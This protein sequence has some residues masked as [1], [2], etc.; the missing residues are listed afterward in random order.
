MRRRDF[1]QLPLATTAAGL[2]GVT[3]AGAVGR[4]DAT[5]AKPDPE[6][7]NWR[8]R[9]GIR[10]P[11]IVVVVLDDIGFADLG[12][13]GSELA[14]R[15]IDGLA[16]NGVRFSNF[17]VTA[18]CA[19]TRACLLTG[20]NAH[21][22]GVGNI[23]EWGRDHPGYRGWIRK[24]AAT[25]AEMLRPLGYTTLA[26]GKWHLSSLDD[27]NGSGPYD[28]WPVGR[29]F[30]RWYGFHGNAMDH[31]HPE[32]FENTVAA[33]PDKSGD[34]HLSADLVERS[35]DYI[36]DHLGATPHKP[37]LH[38]LAFGA[39]HFPLHAPA[40]DIRRH[41]GRYDDGWDAV[42][43]RRFA[44]QKE[45]RIIPADTALAPRNPKISAWNA[46]SRE[47]RQVAKR[48]Q[49]V[50]AAFLEH[51]DAQ[52]ER[53]VDFLKAEDE[54]DDTIILVLSDNGAASASGGNILDAMIDVRRVAYYEKESQQELVE[55]IEQLGTDQSYGMYGS[56]WS[57]ASN[58]PLKWY[59][60]D[61]YGG[62]TRAPLVVSWPAAGFGRGQINT[63][64]AH[65][66]DVVPTLL[67]MLNMPAV[68]KRAAESTLP[69]Q[70]V[71]FA[72]TLDHGDAATRKRVQ[73]FETS[74]DRA[75]WNDGWKAVTRHEFG[76]DFDEDT[77]ELFNT[78]HDFSEI[79]NL[80][81]SEPERLSALVALWH[82]LA[83]E[84]Q[85]LPM[86]DDLL[87]L[88]QQAVPPPR[89]RYVFYPG[90]T[91]LDRLSAPDV[92]SFRCRFEA[93]VKLRDNRASGV[94]LASGDS[95]AG[96]EWFMQ[97]G[98][99]NFYYVY[100]RSAHRHV[101]SAKRIDRQVTVLG[102]DIAPGVDGSATVRLLADGDTVGEI[103]LPQMWQIYAPNSGI[104][105]GENRHA[106]ISRR[107]EAPFVFDHG[108]TKI[109]A[110][111][112]LPE[113]R[114][115]AAAMLLGKR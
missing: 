90:M 51:T 42:R 24:D 49:E 52:L 37:F 105:C 72:H 59:K 87:T 23:A 104:R 10:V 3:P 86:N 78:A 82:E 12:C 35:I 9:E 61:T 8:P 88:Y 6:I 32:M 21:A 33:Y 48:A 96:Y 57:Q 47:Q 55:R 83:A 56:G 18:L 113:N 111:V 115:S 63:Q 58:T 43:Q 41:R 29:G 97:D 25:L 64:Y 14:T 44:R 34:Y 114:Q 4:G 11:N 65:V 15:C 38:Y 98:Y 20:R 89:R 107:Y 71:S 84:D 13:Y 70:G 81:D 36:K 91:R 46:L 67:E 53:L 75:I 5:G 54:F 62:G 92:Y 112:D 7:P 50:Y 85:V 69:L 2:L 19:P 28:H 80:A 27:Q 66:T 26:A 106:P 76:R 101:R 60:G 40:D 108:L 22:V 45:L 93:D 77:W 17:H 100:T 39:C 102:L 30:D 95:G 103:A 109:V 31:W 99:L 73:Y 94:L 110:R 74:G 68:P 1:L 16:T 79:D